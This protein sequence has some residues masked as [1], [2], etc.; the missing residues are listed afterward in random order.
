MKNYLWLISAVVFICSCNTTNKDITGSSG[1]DPN[2]IKGSKGLHGYISFSAPKPPDAFRYGMS[3][4]SAVW[5]LTDKPLANFQIGLPSAWIL[6]LNKDVDFPLCPEGTLAR[7]WEPRGPTWSSVFQ[8]IE[9]GLGYWRGNHFRY[10][11]PKFSMNG[12]PSCYDYEVASP[13]WSFFYSSTPLPDDKMGIAQLS[14]RILV[15]P[16]GLTF[17]GKPNGQ[18]LGYAW[19]ALPLMDAR[20]GTPPVGDQSWTLFLELCKFQGSGGVLYC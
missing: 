4:Y 14:N 1:N 13:G 3:F 10:A 11:S 17:Q 12:V 18:F 6:P 7:T 19:M 2:V 8:T 16:D 20:D 5:P 15:P 9:G